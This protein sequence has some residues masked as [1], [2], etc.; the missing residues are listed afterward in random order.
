MIEYTV[1]VYANGDVEWLLNDDYHREGDK[2]A[3]ERAD[4]AKFW[5]KN[6]KRH[7]EGDK[8]AIIRVD[9]TKEWHVNGKRHRENGAAVEHVS[10]HKEYW[11]NGDY[12]SK[13]AHAE[14]TQ[15][16]KELTVADIEKLLGHKVKV[17]K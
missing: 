1:K 8:P 12:V 10:G 17:V 3:I 14:L 4:G 15:P 7:R 5:F 6:D 13:A 2:P 9:G 11:L 16:T